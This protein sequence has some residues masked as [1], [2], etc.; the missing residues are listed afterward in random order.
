MTTR[1]LNQLTARSVAAAKDGFHSDGGNLYLRVAKGR[2]SWVF[3]S[4]AKS[5]TTSIG[6]GSANAVPLAKARDE[7][8]RLRG[9]IAEGKNPLV[10]RRRVEAEREK[11][12]TFA[13][14]ADDVIKN[15]D[16]LTASS[17]DSWR[18]SLHHDAKRL[19]KINVADID[20]EHVK[21]VVMPIFA[22]GEH[23]SA[24]RTLG[25]IRTVL[26]YAI[27]NSLRSQGTNVA[28]WD[29]F[30]EIAPLRPKADRRHRM[31]TWED[32]P[33]VFASLSDS[34]SMSARCIELIALTAVRLTEARAS[35]WS[36]FDFDAREW[37]I[38]ASRMKARV[39][40]TVPLS[41]Q[42]VD[43]LAKLK[44]HRAVPFVFFGQDT[45]RPVT[46]PACW[47]LCV[48]VTDGRGSPHGWRATFRSWCAE[49]GVDR[50]AAE[51]ALAHVIGGTE[52]SY[53][54]A[55]MI[56]R[57]RPIMQ[58]WADY[59]TDKSA[60]SKVVPFKAKRG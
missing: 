28:T 48:R 43:L 45:R 46:S 60:T 8:K 51:S 59:L 31:I 27:A 1:R 58:A 4:V 12:K 30:K 13:Q 39:E 36:E 49:E 11:Q 23:V 44:A 33:T 20:I 42:A 54:R 3:R 22:R 57:R 56:K 29:V 26:A 53:N 55:E 34:E 50:E 25:R 2:R 5:K 41:D 16:A 52:G 24:K 32:A 9:L 18:R 21:Q 37:T 35:K 19:A 15:R 10:E 7:A 38:P 40:H 47:K 14:A 6:L 17:L